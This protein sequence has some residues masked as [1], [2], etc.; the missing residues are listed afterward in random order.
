M[1]Q[2][3]KHPDLLK[4][5]ATQK[6][7]SILFS[8]IASFSKISERMNPDD[9][10]KLLNDYY[11]A[12]IGCVHQTDGTVMNLIGDAIFAI[13]NAPQEQA[14]HQERAV[15]AALLLNEKLLHFDTASLNLPLRTR[16]G[17]HTGV[18][19]VGNIGSSTHFGSLTCPARVYSFGP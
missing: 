10:V 16:I 11:E 7:V 19:C 18:V 14:D 3:L 15:R 4:P 2:I 1:Q 8:D 6:T 13:W 5:G 9:L 12:A 17:L